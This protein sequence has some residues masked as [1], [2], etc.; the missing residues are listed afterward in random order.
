MRAVTLDEPPDVHVRRLAAS[1]LEFC[2][3]V[4][5]ARSALVTGTAL[6]LAAALTACDAGSAFTGS[7]GDDPSPAASEAAAAAQSGRVH[8]NVRTGA[9]DVPVDQVLA[10]R[11][12]GSRLT[13]VSVAPTSGDGAGEVAGAL[14][15][16][17]TSWTATGLLEPGTSYVLRARASAADGA[18]VRRVAR[19]S[20]RELSLEEQTYASVAPLAGETVGVGMPVVV[21]F[22]VPVTDRASIE[23]HLHVTSSPVQR[24]SWRWISDTEVHWRPKRYWR[25]GTDVTVDVDINSVPAGGGVYGQESRRIEFHVG[26]ANVYKVDA[27]S[28]QMQVFSNGKLLRKLPITTGKAGFTTRSGTKVIMEKSEKRR[29]NS[30]TVGIAA[31]SSEAYDINDV[32]WAMRLT[33]SGEFIHAAP[34]SVGSQG[35]ENVSHGCTGLS[36]ADAGWLY[37]MSK[38]GDVVE[39]VGT[40]RPMTLDNGYGD[41][42]ASFADYR[43]GSALS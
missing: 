25:A 17:E 30:E 9:T 22:D 14:S 5:R 34:W 6:V 4:S 36:T 10:V 26:D 37:A 42:N 18:T 7:A 33:H 31:G 8:A 13:S 11:A 20:T 40:D 28:H 32:R 24:G 2:M 19:F 3:F 43:Q 41:W 15:A 23:Q 1:F 21:S 39:Y 38:R 27:K 29:M 16:D 35:R 12:E